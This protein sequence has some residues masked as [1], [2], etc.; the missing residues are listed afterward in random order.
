MGIRQA[1]LAMQRRLTKAFIAADWR[2]VVLMRA[3]ITEDGAGGFVTGEP[4]PLPS[5]VMRL[6]AQGS[7]GA[8]SKQRMTAN[9]QQVTPEY[10]LLGLHDADIQRWDSFELDGRRYEVVFVNENRQYEAKGEVAYLG[11]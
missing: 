8:D 2:S 7:T 6:I 9:G 1:E 5:Q 10:I 4:A 11:E 3:E